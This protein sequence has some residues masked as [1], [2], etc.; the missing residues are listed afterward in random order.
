MGDK[1]AQQ[2]SQKALPSQ[3]PRHKKP[4]SSRGP[5][6]FQ[7]YIPLPARGPPLP[8]DLRLLCFLSGQPKSSASFG[9]VWSWSLGLQLTSPVSQLCD[10]LRYLGQEAL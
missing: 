7:I 8:F 5:D 6:P 10:S 9:V 2:E 1:V 4:D 3:L